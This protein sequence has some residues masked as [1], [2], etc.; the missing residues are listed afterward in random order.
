MR[1]RRAA[2]LKATPNRWS[3]QQVVTELLGA[4]RFLDEEIHERNC[5]EPGVAIGL[6][7]TPAGG[8]V[9]FVE[10]SRM[11]GTGSLTLTGQLGE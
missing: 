8:D 7:W 11:P 4:P 6:A 1:R 2:A 10:A 5:K 9:L 3:L